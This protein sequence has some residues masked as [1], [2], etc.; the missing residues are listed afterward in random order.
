MAVLCCH[1]YL[2]LSDRWAYGAYLCCST[3]LPSTTKIPDRLYAPA[4]NSFTQQTSKGFLL[5]VKNDG[6]FTRQST[7]EAKTKIR[8]AKVNWF[9]I[10]GGAQQ[11]VQVLL[12]TEIRLK[13]AILLKKKGE[14]RF[15][16]EY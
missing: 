12:E 15:S 11:V 2:E 3:K 6:Y 14:H 9:L 5:Y 8:D 13:S 1:N 16:N 10:I 4:S 7:K